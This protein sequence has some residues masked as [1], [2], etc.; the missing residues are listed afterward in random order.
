[1]KLAVIDSDRVIVNV[2]VP[3]VSLAQFAASGAFA[4]FQL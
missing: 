1:V 3:V 2:Q 4:T